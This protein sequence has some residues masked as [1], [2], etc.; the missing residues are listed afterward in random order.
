MSTSAQPPAS[1]YDGLVSRHLNRRLSRPVA[2]LL[3]KSPMTPNQVTV[4][5]LCVATGSLAAFAFGVPI[6]GGLLAQAGSVIDG[7][8]GDL[9]R[10]AGRGTKFGSFFDAVV[11]RYSDALV[12]LGLTLWAASGGA[13]TAAWA[14]G[15]AALSGSFA[16][17]YTR[18]RVDESRRTMFD[19]GVASLASRDVRLLLVMIGALAGGLA[20]GGG[21]AYGVGT[22]IA[23]A[24]LTNGV[25]LLRVLNAR[26]ALAGE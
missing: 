19:R 24:T 20:P 18:A 11:D 17:T 1:A 23:L 14:A 12:L 10:F 2:R 25:V 26:R 16:V 13:G 6:A 4:V 5:S 22:L 15:F 8:D 9:A 21:P 7:V 3:A